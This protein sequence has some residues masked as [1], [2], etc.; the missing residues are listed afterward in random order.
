MTRACLLVHGI[1]ASPGQLAPQAEA[2]RV[3]GYVVDAPL[4]SGHG[5]DIRDMRALRWEDWYADVLRAATGLQQR[6]GVAQCDY[7]GLSF[8]ALL[9]LQLA[10]DRPD[11]VRRLVCIGTP[12][13]LFRWMRWLLPVL[14]SP[15]L[16]WY[17]DWPKDFSRA[18]AD[19][20]GRE[21]YRAVSYAHFP[22]HAVQEIQRLQSTVRRRLHT[23][24]TPLLLIHARQD[25]TAKP[26]SVALIEHAVHAP[27]TVQWLERSYHVATL[28]YEKTIVNQS[29]HQFLEG[30]APGL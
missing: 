11:L 1:T 19:P 24:R 28:D 5:T 7:V 20:A 3:A 18:V 30:T 9:G 6:T 10:L 4:L 22:L 29:I 2:L 21:I 27:V 12:L 14:R 26:E 15:F 17:H 16:R 8:G 25:R 13:T 23:L